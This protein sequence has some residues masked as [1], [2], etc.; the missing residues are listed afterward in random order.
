[1]KDGNIDQYIVEF[2]YL[3]HHAGLDVNNGGNQ[4][5]FVQGLPQR[6]TDACIDVSRP[7]T[8]EEWAAAAQY[9][10]QGWLQKQFKQSLRNV[11]G[12]TQPKDTPRTGN[13]S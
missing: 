7:N 12:S 8:F 10:Q 2:Q 9:Y 4:H 3:A 5:L 11:F 13:P 6:L 1:M